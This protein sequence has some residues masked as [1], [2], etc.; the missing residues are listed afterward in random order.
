VRRAT[1]IVEAYAYEVYGQPTIKTEDG[2]DA[3]PSLFVGRE[4]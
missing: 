3:D 1:G 4:D 2:G